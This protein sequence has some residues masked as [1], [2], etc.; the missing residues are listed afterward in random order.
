VV[1]VPVAVN[2]YLMPTKDDL[3]DPLRG[4]LHLL[5][6]DEERGPGLDLLQQP[7]EAIQPPIRPVV[8]G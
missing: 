2:R 7:E 1:S 6:D 4:V 5:P 3:L 8:E